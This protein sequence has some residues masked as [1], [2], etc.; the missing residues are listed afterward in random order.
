G[1]G[2]AGGLQLDYLEERVDRTP[3]CPARPVEQGGGHG[4]PLD[5]LPGWIA[6]PTLH[7][8]EGL[9][10]RVDRIR[11]GRQQIDIV[12]MNV[13]QL[14]KRG[15]MDSHDWLVSEQELEASGAVVCNHQVRCDQIWRNVVAG[16]DGSAAW[17]QQRLET[18]RPVDG[19]RVS[20]PEI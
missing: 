19:A 20:L 12:R 16:R 8:D 18:S 1:D 15:T 4:A 3:G 2:H 5:A 9:V 13:R 11:D 17:G 6:E 14:D 7:C 10:D